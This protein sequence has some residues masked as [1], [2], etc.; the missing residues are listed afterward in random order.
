MTE[1]RNWEPSNPANT[2]S[3][4][5]RRTRGT[6][7][8]SL[9][10]L[11]YI[12]PQQNL[13]LQ[14][15][16]AHLSC[17]GMNNVCSEPCSLH[18][19]S[20][21]TQRRAR[22]YGGPSRTRPQ[23]SGRSISIQEGHA[24]IPS[25]AGSAFRTLSSSRSW[26]ARTTSNDGQITGLE[27]MNQRQNDQIQQGT[28]NY[29]AW[30]PSLISQNWRPSTEPHM[31]LAGNMHPFFSSTTNDRLPRP[32]DG[33]ADTVDSVHALTFVEA[34]GP[35]HE[36][37]SPWGQSHYPYVPP[38]YP[39][40]DP[41]FPFQQDRFVTPD[42]WNQTE[43]S[44]VDRPWNHQW[45]IYNGAAQGGHYPE[46]REFSHSPW[47]PTIGPRYV[48]QTPLGQGGGYHPNHLSEQQ[49]SLHWPSED[50]PGPS[51]WHEHT[52][53]TASLCHDSGLLS[54]NWMARIGT[55]STSANEGLV[56]GSPQ[57]R[58][59][60]ALGDQSLHLNS[61]GS[62]NTTYQGMDQGSQEIRPA[63]KNKRKRTPDSSSPSPGRPKRKA[64]KAKRPKRR[65]TKEEKAMI[66]WKRENHT[67]CDDCRE[68][69]RRV[70][71]WLRQSILG[72][73]ICSSATTIRHRPIHLFKAPTPLLPIHSTL[74]TRLPTA[75]THSLKNHPLPNWTIL[76]RTIVDMT[77][78]MMILGPLRKAS[79]IPNTPSPEIRMEP[80]FWGQHLW[81]AIPAVF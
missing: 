74:S 80:C 11:S 24:N 21:S 76:M 47:G 59:G 35:S 22:S 29:R 32:A 61:V 42:T 7:S 33:L 60:A 8:K 2:G 71:F 25:Q 38:H 73:L 77:A 34:P 75:L 53:G 44:P 54:P 39:Q 49:A 36:A 62:R 72:R 23:M 51:A 10:M 26:E 27:P 40:P 18:S 66:K 28:A 56:S 50:G 14:E 78:K 17:G 20:V 43:F 13:D 9:N 48:D 30:S 4:S 6:E 79:M 1:Q 70:R 12:T 31:A 58:R 16:G 52:P 3:E 81:L 5:R 64:N 45:Q 15:T 57:R 55:N 37:T 46:S 65:F 19:H 69:K 67:V 63:Q 41:T 68:A